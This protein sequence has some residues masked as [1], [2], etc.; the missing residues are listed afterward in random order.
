VSGR[1]LPAGRK[2]DLAAHVVEVGQVTVGQLAE[3]FDVSLDTIR[4]DLDQLDA[5]GVI[6]RT[7]GGALSPSGLPRPDTGL[8]VRRR[9]QTEA[10]ERIG[11]LAATLVDDGYALLI[12]AGTT[13]LTVARHLRDRRD[14]TVATNNLQLPAEISPKVFRDLYVFGGAVRLSAMAT[15]G[16]VAF[17]NTLTGAD[18]DIR[19]DLA[20]IAVGAVS[21]DTGYSTSNIGEAA[22]MSEMMDRGAQV[23]IL[24]DSSKFGRRLFAQVAELA[25]ADYLVTDAMPPAELAEALRRHHVEVLTPKPAPRVGG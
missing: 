25:R 11:A 18:I 21:V 20:F 8:E 23:A 19:C 2:A 15:V 12:N 16:P 10:K 4:R 17:P 3:R 6:I 1:R 22:M 14:L 13:T 9:V 24:A 7:H 5:D